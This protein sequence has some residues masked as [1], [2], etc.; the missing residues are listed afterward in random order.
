LVFFLGLDFGSEEDFEL[1]P[2]RSQAAVGHL[3]SVSGWRSQGLGQHTFQSSF[4][5]ESESG[6]LLKF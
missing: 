1:M 6:L 4:S 2:D 3:S 5:I